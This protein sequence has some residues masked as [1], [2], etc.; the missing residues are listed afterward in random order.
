MTKQP[1]ILDD[2]CPSVH[3]Q[4][5]CQRAPPS[6]F[7]LLTT[8]LIYPGHHWNC[9]DRVQSGPLNRIGCIGMTRRHDGTRTEPPAA[10][11]GPWC[12]RNE[13]AFLRGYHST[14]R[15]VASLWTHDVRDRACVVVRANRQA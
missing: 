9:G 5:P 15:M 10:F 3:G 14:A 8:G 6:V 11:D 1:G 2:Y 13:P 4:I 7:G 12:C